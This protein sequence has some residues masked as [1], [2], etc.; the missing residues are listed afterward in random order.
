[1]SRPYR[2]EDKRVKPRGKS[3]DKHCGNRK[4]CDWCNRTRLYQSL[5]EVERVEQDLENFDFGDDS[6]WDIPSSM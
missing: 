5:K 4:D 1:M 2:N 3:V 6:D